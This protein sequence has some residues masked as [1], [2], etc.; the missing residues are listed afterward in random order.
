MPSTT[1]KVDYDQIAH[2]YDEPGRDFEPDPDLLRFLK[3]RARLDLSSLRVLD[4]GC[5]TGKQ[6]T[7]DHARL[8][9][10]RLA[11]LDLFHGMLEQARKRCAAIDWVQADSTH[12]PFPDLSF[13]YI[14]N[15]FSYPHISD[16]VQLIRETYRI[17]KPGGQFA[18]TN[19]D[20]WSMPGWVLYRFFPAALARDLADFLSEDQLV[21][22]LTQA[23]FWDIQVRRQLKR[24]EEKLGDFLAYA[25]Q[26]Y[27]TSHFMAIDD[28]AYQDGLAAITESI[29][30]SGPDARLPSELC[31]IWFLADKPGSGP[32]AG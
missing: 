30:R 12:P 23:G 29:R 11:G 31:L 9:G 21:S 25:S 26:R 19:I 27:R 3:R 32:A 10:L 15:Q 22:M 20:P 2:L 7:A 17:L 16:K 4:M 13:D 18:I 8:P 24:S 14:T 28:Q 1:R 5:G 6:L